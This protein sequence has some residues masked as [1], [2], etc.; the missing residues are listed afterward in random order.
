MQLR[1]MGP[2]GDTY[3]IGLVGRAV[4]TRLRRRRRL[5]AAPGGS[6]GGVDGRLGRAL[7]NDG[8]ALGAEQGAGPETAGRRVMR[9]VGVD[10]GLHGGGGVVPAS[11]AGGLVDDGGGSGHWAGAEVDVGPEAVGGEVVGLVGVH[12]AGLCGDGERGGG[13]MGVAA[14]EVGPEDNGVADSPAKMGGRAGV[15]ALGL[16]GFQRLLAGLEGLLELGVGGELKATLC[17]TLRLQRGH[18]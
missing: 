3:D 12:A 8:H 6:G 10:A 7:A 13:A 16:L 11:G 1:G 18:P 4:A 9:G 15:A 14:V 5:I 17:R 2:P